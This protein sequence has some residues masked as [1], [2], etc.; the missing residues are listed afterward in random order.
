MCP[1]IGRS[2]FWQYAGLPYRSPLYP[3]ISYTV[4]PALQQN[5][6]R[7]HDI[8]H[9]GC[10]P[11]STMS[12]WIWNCQGSPG[13]KHPLSHIYLPISSSLQ[14]GILQSFSRQT[15]TLFRRFHQCLRLLPIT[16]FFV[17]WKP[18]PSRFFSAHKYIQVCFLKQWICNSLNAFK[19]REM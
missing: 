6:E 15:P 8:D 14:E 7:L 1:V 13:F 18:S 5:Y 3:I 11:P 10:L 16:K 9:W 12:S 17:A 19:E 4:S 2:Q